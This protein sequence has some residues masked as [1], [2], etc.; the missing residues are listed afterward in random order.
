M[1]KRKRMHRNSQAAKSEK[2]DIANK[3]RLDK[4]L[5]ASRSQGLFSY[6]PKEKKKGKKGCDK[7]STLVA[8]QT[9][10]RSSV[11]HIPS[12]SSPPTAP[13]ARTVYDGEM[14]ERERLAQEEVERKKLRTAP[15]YNKGGYQYITDDT[16]LSD[17]GRKK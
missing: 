7:S 14:E 17:L 5:A 6:S 8:S 11:D 10:R 15:L 2:A 16:D 3:K 4:E 9:Y 1:A 12:F 13:K